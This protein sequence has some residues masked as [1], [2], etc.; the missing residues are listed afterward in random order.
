MASSLSTSEQR[1]IAAGVAATAD[2]GA[3]AAE[4]SPRTLAPLLLS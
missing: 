1:F 2:V 4:L 3:T